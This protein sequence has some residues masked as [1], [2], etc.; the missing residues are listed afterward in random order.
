M[1]YEIGIK[2]IVTMI[3]EQPI[4]EKKEIRTYDFA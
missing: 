3:W 2:T 4:K 1:E